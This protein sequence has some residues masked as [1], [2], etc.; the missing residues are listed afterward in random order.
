MN[1]KALLEN[2]TIEAIKLSF[3]ESILGKGF[4]LSCDIEIVPYNDAT[5]YITLKPKDP[6]KP[7]TFGEILQFGIMLGRDFLTDPEYQVFKSR[8]EERLEQIHN[9]KKNNVKTGNRNDL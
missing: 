9:Y 3:E 8:K 5:S 6:L 2:D 1:L 7:P 4:A